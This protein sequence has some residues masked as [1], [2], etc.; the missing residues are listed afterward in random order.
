MGDT[1]ERGRP[2]RAKGPDLA[3]AAACALLVLALGA[4]G[5]ARS[6]AADVEHRATSDERA[7][8]G[9]AAEVTNDIERGLR[10][11]AAAAAA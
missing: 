5:V 11:V 6:R 2:G 7:L 10:G 9:V 4:A 3:A 1:S 8:G